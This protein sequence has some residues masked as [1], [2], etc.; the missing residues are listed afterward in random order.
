MIDDAHIQYR[1]ERALDRIDH[2]DLDGAVDALRE[3]LA[4]DPDVVEAHALLAL[5]FLDLQAVA[6][7]RAE[8]QT[9]V[10]LDG[11]NAY[12]HHA[13]GDVCIAEGKLEEAAHHF[14]LALAIEPHSAE[15]YEAMARLDRARRRPYRHWLDQ[16]LELAPDDPDI[17]AALANERFEQGDRDQARHLADQALRLDPEN[18]EALL[19]KAR[20]LLAEGDTADAREHVVAALRSNAADPDALHL[21]VLVRA[22]ANPALGVLM[23]WSVWMET[24]RPGRRVAWLVGLLMASRLL[25]LVFTD[26]GWPTAAN[27]VRYA[28]LAFV[29]YTW[30]GPLVLQWQLRRELR[31][32]SLDDDY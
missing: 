4:L 21:L 25:T 24:M 32:V 1:L 11:D 3:L 6:P 23:R 14:E 28:W 27:V 31:E 16:A 5:C 8:A 19:A 15:H 10:A 29:A 13:M 7:A 18:P 17:H 26:L 12:A 20:V 2:H 9:A 30:V 22:R